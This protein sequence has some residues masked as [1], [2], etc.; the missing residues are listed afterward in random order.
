MTLARA[1]GAIAY[2]FLA[3]SAIANF[4][5]A[6][7]LA[8]TSLLSFVYGS[9]GVL[10]TAANA[11]IP[12][13]MSQAWEARN[14][15]V[16]V[17]GAVFLPLCIAFSLTSAIGFAASVRDT[18]TAD[19]AALTQNYKTT[20]AMLKD[21]EAKPKTA[22]TE[23]RI[24][25]LRLEVKSYR[26]RGALLQDDPQSAALQIFGLTDGR[27]YL[28]LLFALLIEF[29]SALGLF[30]ALADVKRKEPAQWRPRTG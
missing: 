24:E 12:L 1:A 27:Y 22:K 21:V 16:L 2:G 13:R 7:S 28:T 25:A 18:S 29:G 6:F 20:L 5:F 30:I 4:M 8:K 26:E 9:V 17:A 3:A 11:V 15:S 14:A 19:R 10:A 23:Q